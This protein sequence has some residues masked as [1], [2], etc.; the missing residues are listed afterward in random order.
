VTVSETR[1]TQRNR[2]RPPLVLPPLIAPFQAGVNETVS[3]TSSLSI[4]T[5]GKQLKK[6]F[7]KR[8]VK[9]LVPNRRGPTYRSVSVEEVGRP[10]EHQPAPRQ[11]TGPRRNRGC[12]EHLEDG[13]A[14]SGVALRREVPRQE[15][16]A[17]FA[18]ERRADESLG[19]VRDPSG[20]DS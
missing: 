7:K 1:L 4:T 2:Y 6:S 16:V 14:R 3:V 9:V 11:P 12:G 19:A 10:G 8:V 5:G 20:S 15:E 13:T 17:E 18:S